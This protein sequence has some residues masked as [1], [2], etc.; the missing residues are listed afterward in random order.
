MSETKYPIKDFIVVGG[1]ADFFHTSGLRLTFDQMIE[2][3]YS[4]QELTLVPLW[5]SSFLVALSAASIA[6]N[7]D[8]RQWRAGRHLHI[9]ARVD[10]LAGRLAISSLAC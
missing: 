1:Y 9:L 6:F 10:A 4:V 7:S 2:R 3:G 8:L 5:R